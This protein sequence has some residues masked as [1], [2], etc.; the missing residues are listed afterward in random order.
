KREHPGALG[1]TPA[2][3]ADPLGVA[4]AIIEIEPFRLVRLYHPILQI[5][6]TQHLT[7]GSCDLERYQC[8]MNHDALV[9]FKIATPDGQVLCSGN[10]QDRVVKSNKT[11][12]LDFY[13]RIRDTQRIGAVGRSATQRSGVLTL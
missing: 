11:K 1:G 6:R 12:R 9:P 3:R 5:P 8:V 7:V 13:Y 10:L 2:D 4:D